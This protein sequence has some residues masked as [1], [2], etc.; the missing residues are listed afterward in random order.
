MSRRKQKEKEKEKRRKWREEGQ[1]AL[2]IVTVCEKIQSP[3]LCPSLRLRGYVVVIVTGLKTKWR[4]T[5][6]FRSYPRSSKSKLRAGGDVHAEKK[7]G[8]GRV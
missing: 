1:I 7:R 8:N 2:G 6:K 3:F 4:P 5:R